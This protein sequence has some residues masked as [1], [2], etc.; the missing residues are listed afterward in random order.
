MFM[1]TPQYAL[2]LIFYNLINKN[3]LILE[4]SDVTLTLSDDDLIDLSLGKLNP[5]KAF[6]QGKLKIAG[7]MGLA[8]KL[9]P[10]LQGEVTKRT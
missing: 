10:L 8:M 5:Q 3:C 1:K 9:Q 7:N 2:V 6:F 4:K